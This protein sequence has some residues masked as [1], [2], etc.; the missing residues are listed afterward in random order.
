[1]AQTEIV[2]ARILYKDFNLEKA[3]QTLNKL[4]QNQIEGLPI[5]FQ[6]QIHTLKGRILVTMGNLGDALTSAEKSYDI[7]SKFEKFHDTIEKINS[8]LLIAEILMSNGKYEKSSEILKNI[9]KMINS[10]PDK[11]DFLKKE[12]SA[13]KITIQAGINYGTG[14]VQ[15]NKELLEVLQEICQ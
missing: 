2:E 5:E 14:K 8:F 3:L 13:E 11:L 7:A 9:D 1:M 10:I 15:E 4:S 6:L 12:K